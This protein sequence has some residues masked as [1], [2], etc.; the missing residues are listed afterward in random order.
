MTARRV[1]ALS[2]LI[3]KGAGSLVQ[4]SEPAKFREMPCLR[5][6][7]SHS[8]TFS[9]GTLIFVRFLVIFK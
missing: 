4:G 9:F 3:Y 2:M 5:T 7:F 8:R 6:F 1:I